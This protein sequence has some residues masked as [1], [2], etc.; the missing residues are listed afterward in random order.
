MKKIFALVLVLVLALSLV[1]FV[2]CTSDKDPEEPKEPQATANI[3]KNYEGASIVGSGKIYLTS[4]GQA[5]F[6]TLKTLVTKS[7]MAGIS[8]PETQINQLL[9]AS[10]VEAG[11]TVV[12]IA[13][14]TTKGLATGVTQASET[15]RAQ[16]FAARSDINLVLI[17]IGGEARRGANSDPMCKAIAQKAKLILVWDD[18][19]GAGGNI[20]CDGE[21]FETWAPA[22][23]LYIFT[24]ET[25][26]VPSIK[27]VLGAN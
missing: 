21:N 20:K 26:L 25:G 7:T 27:K 2:A 4:F 15:A 13:G 11:S 10:A 17:H 24:E 12:C 6:S 3:D 14:Y 18:G 16:A 1:T 9:E 5:D 19:A 8:V 22:G 23:T